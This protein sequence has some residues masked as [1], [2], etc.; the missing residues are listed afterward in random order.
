MPEAI[1]E[2]LAYGPPLLLDGALGSLLM[3]R[4]LPAG[5]PPEAWVLQNPQALSKT[6]QDY[7]E[8]GAEVLT[9]CT[10]GANRARLERSGLQESLE[11]I[12]RR[13]V[14]L[15]R[16]AAG[17][18]LWVAGDM[19]PTGEFLQPHGAM[20]PE[21]ALQIYAEQARI[22]ADC[23]VDFFLLETHY[24]LQ[25][26][27]INV[28]ACRQT[29]PEIPVAVTL[30]FSRTPR[31][32]F[33]V[34]GNPAISSLRALHEAGAFLVGANCTLDAAGMLDLARE[35]APA[36]NAPLLFQPNAGTPQ[37]TPAG[38]EYPQNSAEFAHYMKEFISLGARAL[39]GCCGTNPDYIQAIRRETDNPLPDRQ[40]P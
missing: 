23:R 11:E 31:G 28:T 3:Q 14:L 13:A 10:F 35:L 17:D 9:T 38:L 40:I 32:F 33:T 19:G 15:A 5:S 16:R 8:A 30:T 34:M 25:E 7:A 20:T 27:L 2:R 18:R 6:H 4:G 39:G 1:T 12:N 24:D 22:L 29:S 26:A 37:I 36:V 21:Q